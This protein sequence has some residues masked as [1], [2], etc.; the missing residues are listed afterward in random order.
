M[1]R[2]QLGILPAWE[3]QAM[4]LELSAELVGIDRT[5]MTARQRR[6]E[7]S[8]WYHADGVKDGHQPHRDR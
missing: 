1:E 7:S 5:P 3:W 8:R 6:E 4:V 2:L